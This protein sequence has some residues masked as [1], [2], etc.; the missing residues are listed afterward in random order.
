[1]DGAAFKCK[2]GLGVISLFFNVTSDCENC[3]ETNGFFDWINHA[4]ES[5]D[6][7][8]IDLSKLLPQDAAMYSDVTGYIGSLTAPPCTKDVCWYIVEDV[9]KIEESELN[10]F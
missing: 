6:E 1:M 7:K 2:T 9:F 8:T 4:E 5:G 3:K 10:H